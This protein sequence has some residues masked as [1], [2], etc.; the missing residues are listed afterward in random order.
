MGGTGRA[1]DSQHPLGRAVD[2]H[3]IGISLGDFWLAAERDPWLRGIG[4][5]PYWVIPGLHLDTRTT[6]LR[7]RWWR[8]QVGTYRPL[9]MQH[10]DTLAR[11]GL[12]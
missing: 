11:D 5:Y 7:M 3:A 6:D 8:D 1:A 9:A 4:L 2:C 12:I 10:V